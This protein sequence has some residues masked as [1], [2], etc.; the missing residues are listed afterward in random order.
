MKNEDLNTEINQKNKPLILIFLTILIVIV[1]S[2]IPSGTK[3]FNY[4]LKNIDFFIDVKPDSI[5]SNDY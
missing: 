4:Q 3:I 5:I 2:F 1:L